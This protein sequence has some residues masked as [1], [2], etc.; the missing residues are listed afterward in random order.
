MRARSG[1]AF[2]SR[3]IGAEP[4]VARSCGLAQTDPR[5]V[6]RYDAKEAQLSLD[7]MRRGAV[8]LYDNRQFSNSKPDRNSASAACATVRLVKTR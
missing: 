7:M 5:P 2:R 1:L 8:I 6:A 4:N 3:P